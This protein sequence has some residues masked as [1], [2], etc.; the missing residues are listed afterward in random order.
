MSCINI[1]NYHTG[2]KYNKIIFYCHWGF[3]MEYNRKKIEDCQLKNWI[4]KLDNST[5]YKKRKKRSRL[6]ITA[7]KALV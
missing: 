6:S 5:F 3:H 7:V 4:L 2:N 1:V